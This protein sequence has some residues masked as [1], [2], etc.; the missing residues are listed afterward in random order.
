MSPLKG[1]KATILL[2]KQNTDQALKIAHQAYVLKIGKIVRRGNSDELLA[3]EK[4]RKAHIAE[5]KVSNNG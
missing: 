3:H 5:V 1:Q 2:M 4:I